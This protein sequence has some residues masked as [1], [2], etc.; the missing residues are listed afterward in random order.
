MPSI[1]TVD[2]FTDRPFGGNPAGVCPLESP[3]DAAW[4]QNVA[5][6]MN[7]AE[8][9]FLHP[10]ADGWRLRWF[11]PTGVEMDLCG[12][13]TLATAHVLWE[14]GALAPESTARFQS[15]SGLLTATRRGEW[16]ELDLPSL[17]AKPIEP[18]ADLLES[19]GVAAVRV[20]RSRDDLLVEV[21]D[22]AA[23]RACRPDFARLRRVK[24]RGVIVTAASAAPEFDFVSRFFAPAVGIDEDPVTGSAHCV[25]APWWAAALGKRT[26][27]AWQASPRGGLLR[28]ELDGERVRLA[29]RAVTV[30]RGELIGDAPRPR[31]A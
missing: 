21:V 12:H 9:A 11:T 1:Y 23:V 13:A 3:A 19:L 25:L 16:I 27:M 5:A 20:A 17:P 30:L 15:R 31:S 29:G 18:P 4:M 14:T 8:T 2:A 22:E 26:F 24:T 28:L 6:E 10:E 7:L